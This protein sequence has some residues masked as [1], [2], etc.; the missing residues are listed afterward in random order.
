MQEPRR[1]KAV[2]TIARTFA[3]GC[4]IVPF[5]VALPQS[6]TAKTIK[7]GD[8]TAASCTEGA[9]RGALTL[10][11]GEKNSV[12]KFQCGTEPVTIV[13]TAT[14]TIPNNATIDGDGAITLD[15]ESAIDSIL[16]VDR[17]TA[18]TLRGLTIDRGGQN[19]ITVTPSGGGLFNDG[20]ATV[21]TCTFSR[22]R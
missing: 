13:V 10:A 9:L 2:M 8:G 5:L 4:L 1:G 17:D 22:N 7:V 3:T 15:G 19:Q 12:I 11:G 16:R 20:T 14:L 6:A 21:D 18:V